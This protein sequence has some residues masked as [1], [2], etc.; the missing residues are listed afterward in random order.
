MDY[1]NVGVYNDFNTFWFRDVGYQI[2][3]VAFINAIFPPLEVLLDWII[4]HFKQRYDRGALFRCC[5]CKSK[6]RTTRQK[7]LYGYK[8]LYSGPDFEIHYKYA[9][10]LTITYVTFLFAPGLPIMFP[11]ALLAMLIL[12]ATNRLQL[13]YFNKKPPCY[14]NSMNDT[15]VVFLKFAP[16]FYVVVGAWLYSNQQTFYNQVF[17]ITSDDWVFMRSG[18]TMHQFI[19]EISPGSVFFVYA[20]VIFLIFLSLVIKNAILLCRKYICYKRNKRFETEDQQGQ[21]L[22]DYQR[23]R[24]NKNRSCGKSLQMFWT[25]AKFKFR[26]K[27]IKDFEVG[28]QELKDLYTSLEYS[29]RVSL[30]SEE[31][32]NWQRLKLRRLS[33]KNLLALIE[34]DQV[35]NKGFMLTGDSSYRILRHESAHQFNY[36]AKPSLQDLSQTDF[37]VSPYTDQANKECSLDVVTAAAYLAFMDPREAHKLCYST[38]YFMQRRKGDS[39]GSA[40]KTKDQASASDYDEDQSKTDSKQFSL[41]PY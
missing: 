16:M 17:P 22:K 40:D 14:S 26:F 9:Q 37:V 1:F 25:V 23:L 32:N 2:V 28:G 18:H 4:K 27:P 35:Q 30:I 11:I 38:E 5:C 31:V 29:E 10:M 3:N 34:V 39:K 36:A 12:Y 21:D 33:K 19:T 6:K 15:T 8:N 20:V 7:T 41:N 13:A 24:D